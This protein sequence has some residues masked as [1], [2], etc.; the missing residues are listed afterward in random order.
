VANSWEVA[1]AVNQSGLHPVTPVTYSSSTDEVRW[2]N[3]DCEKIA[4]KRTMKMTIAIA[5]ARTKI[6][7]F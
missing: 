1:L 4:L 3:F 7:H 6:F 5:I 2:I